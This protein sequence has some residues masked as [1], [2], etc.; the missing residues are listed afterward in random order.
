MTRE[1]EGAAPAVAEALGELWDLY[2]YCDETRRFEDGPDAALAQWLR[3]GADC[4]RWIA[5]VA[6]AGRTRELPPDLLNHRDFF[7]AHDWRI[8]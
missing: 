6:A 4:R 1:F 5:V 7:N 8:P 2:G 3:A